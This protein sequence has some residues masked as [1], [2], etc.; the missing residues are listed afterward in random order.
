M[1]VL[2]ATI[3]LIPGAVVDVVRVIDQTKRLFVLQ[4]C[5]VVLEVV[6]HTHDGAVLVERSVGPGADV[7]ESY[8]DS[9][10]IS[11]SPWDL[12]LHDSFLNIK[13][14]KVTQV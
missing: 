3:F 6:E 9:G 13:N 1:N 12:Q 11:N 2:I 4:S 14:L 8:A 5:A 7:I 10:P